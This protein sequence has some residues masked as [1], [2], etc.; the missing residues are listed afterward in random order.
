VGRA[1]A[2]RVAAGAVAVVAL[3]ALGGY[4]IGGRGGVPDTDTLLDIARAAGAT[5]GLFVAAGYAPARLLLP[6][7]LAGHLAL[8]VLPVGAAV[9]ALA[10]TV[11]GVA[12]LPL[13]ASLA[14]LLAAGAVGAVVVGRAPRATVR[15]APV[16]WP[17]LVGL[18]VFCILISPLLPDWS[19]ATVLGQNGDAH[20]ATGAA[21]LLQHEP[22]GGVNEALPIDRMPGAWG[23]K[24]PI[25]YVLAAASTLSGLDPVQAFA[26]V[27]AVVGALVAV[28]FYLLAVH[29]LGTGSGA[30][31]LAMGLVALDRI[32]VRLAFD[33]FYNQLWALFALPFV[34]VLGWRFVREPSRGTGVLLVLFLALAAFAYPLLTPFPLLFLGVAAWRERPRL[35]LPRAPL[36]WV[37]IALL[38]V[39]AA[40]MAAEAFDKLWG[41]LKAALPGGDLDP[42]TGTALGFH[43]LGHFLG[44]PDEVNLLSLAVLAVAAYGLLRVRE[45][46]ALPYGVLVAALGLTALWFRIRG[47]PLFHFKA[48]SFMG[49][50]ALAL[51]AVALA[52]LVRRPRTVARVAA[53][54]AGLALATALVVNA[55]RQLDFTKPHVTDQVWELR[56]WNDRIPAG[57]SIRVDVTPIGVQQWAWYMLAEH[58]IS[59]SAPL[60]D[61]FPFHPIGRRAD[62]LLVNRRGPRP[63]DAAGRPVLR[64]REFALYRMRADVPGPDV[65][66]R[67]QFDPV[68]LGLSSGGE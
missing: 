42:W 37:A 25:Y 61:F 50:L 40:L 20:L 56:E 38:A 18:A 41:A 36:A 33:P 45:G 54:A 59:A 35:S 58:P 12:R 17:A 63:R 67:A 57:A 30:A 34:L 62:Y 32:V 60:T 49:P 21:E 6:R 64:N 68:V 46:V 52:D 44:L 14:L 66:S 39:P 23:S 9:S 47:G 11:L 3:I 7:A 22:P 19:F 53:V 2:A 43:P 51:V 27:I 65:S 8:F 29:V 55:R 1:Q 24:Y 4:R 31:L 5:V 16:L 48:L 10:L 26:T 15:R 13:E 28:G